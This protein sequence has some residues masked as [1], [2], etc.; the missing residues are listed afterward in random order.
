MSGAPRLRSKDIADSESRPVLG[1]TGNNASPL[2]FQKSASKSLRKID[3]SPEEGK[4][5]K[6]KGNHSSV[7]TNTSSP[8]LHSASA[9]TML[10]RHQQL[11][12]SNLSLN[13]SCSSDAS[14]DS[15]QSRA[16]TGRLLRSTSVGSRRKPNI[17]KPRSVVSD[18][19]LDFGLDSPPPLG[20][21]IKKCA[22]VTPNTG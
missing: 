12:Q 1:P 13:A 3:G 19:G 11:L 8:K 2:G 7:V 16:S 18:G 20:L 15:F 22:W 6:E 10:R 17:S 14:T 21:Q 5:S 4:M 9:A